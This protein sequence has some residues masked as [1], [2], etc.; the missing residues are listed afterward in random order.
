[1]FT[2]GSIL[3]RRE[4]LDLALMGKA[5]VL[6]LLLGVTSEFGKNSTLMRAMPSNG[7]AFRCHSFLKTIF[8]VVLETRLIQRLITRV[9]FE[10]ISLYA[11]T[12]VGRFLTDTSQKRSFARGQT[13]PAAY[14]TIFS[15]F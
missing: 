5:G 2:P 10:K 8:F 7:A 15:V 3:E 12:G 1:M 9:L 13:M 4:L 6:G 14:R 11:S